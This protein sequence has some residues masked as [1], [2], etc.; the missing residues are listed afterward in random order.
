M[1]RLHVFK[2]SHF[3]DKA[4]W[5]QVIINAAK[6]ILYSRLSFATRASKSGCK[7]H[8][9]HVMAFPM[10]LYSIQFFGRYNGSIQ[11]KILLW[12]LRNATG[13]ATE[14]DPQSP[15]SK[16]F[17]KPKQLGRLVDDF[18]IVLDLLR[19]SKIYMKNNMKNYLLQL[20]G[21]GV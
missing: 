12:M 20:E 9:F 2:S 3:Q 17:L 21:N 15:E 19:C 7:H 6:E 10:L 8:R 13:T 1:Y 11:W 4:V 18:S 16:H 5:V 14:L